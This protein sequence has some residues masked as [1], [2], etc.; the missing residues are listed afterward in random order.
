M[1]KL[2]KY[3]L[4]LMAGAA[5]MLNSCADDP[6]KDIKVNKPA[7]LENKVDYSNLPF[8][9]D[10]SSNQNLKFGGSLAS[11]DFVNGGNFKSI[12]LYNFS[13]IEAAG[14]NHATTVSDDGAVSFS[15]YKEFVR[16]AA[17][18]NV[19]VYGAPLSSVYNQNSKYLEKILADKKEGGDA[20]TVDTEVEETVVMVSAADKVADAWDSQF[21]LKTKDEFHNGDSYEVSFEYRADIPAKAST[22]LHAAPGEYKSWDGLGD[23]NFTTSWQT[24]TKAGTFNTLKPEGSEEFNVCNSIAFNLNEYAKANNYMFR[25]ISVKVNGTEQIENGDLKGSDIS[26]FVKKE[27]RA[28]IVQAPITKEKIKTPVELKPGEHYTTYVDDTRNC[29]AVPTKDMVLHQW[30]TQF[31]IVT[32]DGFKAGDSYEFT[33]EVRC[34]IKTG[35]S[36]GT[37]NHSLEQFYI[38]GDGIGS[39]EFTEGNWN[40]VKLEGKFA[41]DGG[42]IALNFNDYAKANCYYFDNVSFKIN[43]VEQ[44]TNGDFETGK[45]H[46][47]FTRIDYYGGVEGEHDKQPRLPVAIINKTFKNA[48][49]NEVPGGTPLTAEER[50]DT[51]AYALNTYIDAMM[52]ATDG[53]VTVFDAFVDPFA[54]NN[55]PFAWYSELGDEYLKIVTDAAK[56]SFKGDVS[57][58]KLFVASKSENLSDV[59]DN[60]ASLEKV[61]IS[62]INAKFVL[63]LDGDVN[64]DIDALVDALAKSG[65]L[66]KITVTD[67]LVDGETANLDAIAK[68]D[69]ANVAKA[70]NYLVKKYISTI[71]ADKQYG[72][73]IEKIK[74]AVF[75][76]EFGRSEVFKGIAN[77]L[78]GQDYQK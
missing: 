39:I 10:A 26:C 46:A 53:K 8:L 30:D 78:Q 24:F 66:A 55:V 41:K 12:T 61:G 52:V 64:A 23:V 37:Q 56:S 19:A 68:S 17:N 21:W 60:M 77:G 7:S 57:N 63:D 4:P 31:W 32:K 74:N 35:M 71:S 47:Q 2:T 69:I 73:T 49:D 76:T 28:D 22:Q 15:A 45:E 42:S 33:A 9:K 1:V 14:I 3:A 16:E 67:V 59:L 48:I 44:I 36:F 50:H 54:V 62:G 72:I 20:V 29:I 43:G 51:L 5:F 25:N 27:D 75:T 40:A 65:K 11:A 6:V 70:Y 13:E 38:S 18:K 34:D 58:L